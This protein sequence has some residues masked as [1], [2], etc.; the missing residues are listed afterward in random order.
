M[1]RNEPLKLTVDFN[2]LDKDDLV[3]AFRDR[4]NHPDL[5]AEGVGV[6]VDDGDGNRCLGYIVRL[7]GAKVY[8]RPEWLTWQD[9]EPVITTPV[10]QLDEALR[11][12]VKR[13]SADGQQTYAI[14]LV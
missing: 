12:L 13:S 9:A 4:A 1:T 3:W 7:T 6:E 2:R 11:L 14:E 5:L 8:V 10:Q